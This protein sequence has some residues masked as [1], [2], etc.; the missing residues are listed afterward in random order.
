MLIDYK[1]VQLFN[2]VLSTQ[3]AQVADDRN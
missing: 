2:L 3:I 1:K